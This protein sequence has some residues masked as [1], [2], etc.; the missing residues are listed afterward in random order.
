MR[1]GRISLPILTIYAPKRVFPAKDM[2]FGIST[3]SAYVSR[4][5]PLKT[6]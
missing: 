1:P 6:P 5:K 3:I 2:P 4:V